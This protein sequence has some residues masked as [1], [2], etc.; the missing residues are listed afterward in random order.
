MNRSVVGG[1][2]RTRAALLCCLALAVSGCAVLGGSG[3]ASGAASESAQETLETRVA[4]L[5]QADALYRAGRWPDAQKAYEQ[6]SARYTRN[7]HVWLRLG[8]TLARQGLYENA[9]VALQNAVLVE[10]THG[11]AAFNLGLVRLAQAQSAFEYAR[12]RLATQ[13]AMR[14]QAEALRRRVEELVAGLDTLAVKD[15]RT[16][17][18]L[19]GA[20]PQ[21]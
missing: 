6:L 4:A 21:P 20:A 12:T 16:E 3:P 5:E 13:P 10:G 8:N 18:A 14:Q 19:A 17:T 9:A 7:A 1:S 2:A 11:A 15:G